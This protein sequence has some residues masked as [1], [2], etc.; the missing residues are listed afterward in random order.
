MEKLETSM[1][2]FSNFLRVHHEKA[3]HFFQRSYAYL[4]GDPLILLLFTKEVYNLTSLN[5]KEYGFMGDLVKKG[6][7]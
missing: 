3:G 5:A 6:T 1:R 7:L 2:A 4:T